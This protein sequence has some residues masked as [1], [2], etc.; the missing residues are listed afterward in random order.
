MGYA[1]EN[2]YRQ[3]EDNIRGNLKFDFKI[4]SWLT[5]KLSGDFNKLLTTRENKILALGSKI[6]KVLSI[7]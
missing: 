6:T 1:F 2:E 7:D 4:T 3:K 5:A